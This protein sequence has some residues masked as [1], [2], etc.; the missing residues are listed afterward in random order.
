[1]P[2]NEPALRRAPVVGLAAALALL[3]LARGDGRDG[4][5]VTLQTPY[6]YLRTARSTTD[7]PHVLHE[8]VSRIP[9]SASPDNWPVHIAGPPAGAL[10]FFV[11]LVRS[12]LGGGL[13]AGLVVTV[14]AA[15]TAP[16]T[17]VAVRA[18]GAEDL[19]RRAAPFLVLG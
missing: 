9:F 10:T 14:L 16:A 4:S 5:G 6:E 1:M 12:G 3:A 8:Y 7:L 19:A 2:P 15:T 18:L 11:L 17:L 13:A